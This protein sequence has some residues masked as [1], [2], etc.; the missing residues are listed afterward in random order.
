MVTEQPLRSTDEGKVK[1]DFGGEGGGVDLKHFRVT[2]VEFV[3]LHSS[4][5]L[6]VRY[7]SEWKRFRDQGRVLKLTAVCLKK[8]MMIQEMDIHNGDK[9]PRICVENESDGTQDRAPGTQ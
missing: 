3:A 1:M 5:I 4:G 9:I 7:N 6:I 2:F 8:A